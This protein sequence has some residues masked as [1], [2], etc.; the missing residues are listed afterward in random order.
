MLRNRSRS[1]LLVALALCLTFLASCSS[2]ASPAATVGGTDITDAQLAHEV[3][4]FSFLSGLDKQPCGT[5]D[6]PETQNAA[7]ARFALSNLIQEHFVTKYAAAHHISVTDARVTQT[8]QQL[9]HLLSGNQGRRIRGQ[10]PRGE[11][12]KVRRFRG[13]NQAIQILAFDEVVAEPRLF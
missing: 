6:G 4:V 2:G 13:L 10:R 12:K 1:L 8:I 9:A 5:V 3:D 7:C 11:D